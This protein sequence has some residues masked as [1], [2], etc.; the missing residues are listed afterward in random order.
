MH[1]EVGTCAEIRCQ[2]THQKV[3]TSETSRLIK[4]SH[5]RQQVINRLT[6]QGLPSIVTVAYT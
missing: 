2:L 1:N 3:K 4:S 5:H 6:F